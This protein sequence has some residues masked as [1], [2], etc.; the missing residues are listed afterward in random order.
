MTGWKVIGPCLSLFQQIEK[1]QFEICPDRFGG[2]LAFKRARLLVQ[3]RLKSVLGKS[4]GRRMTSAPDLVHPC[5]DPLETG[6]NCFDDLLDRLVDR[7]GKSRLVRL[8]SFKRCEL[9]VKKA[10]WHVVIL[11]GRHAIKQYLP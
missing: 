7:N 3:T 8:G 11:A 9:T 10:C 2:R 1:A 5:P 4:K 6:F